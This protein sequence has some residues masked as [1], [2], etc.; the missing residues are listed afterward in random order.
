MQQNGTKI[1]RIVD[2]IGKQSDINHIGQELQD[3]IARNDYEYI[4]FYC[5]GI[6]NEIL[7]NAGLKLKDDS[8]L[9]TIPNYFEPFVQEN[10]DIYYFTNCN[11]IFPIFK[12]DGDQDRPSFVALI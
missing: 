11:E 7:E 5:E 3:L 1:L 9:N 10:I 12:A 6:E 4:D 2:F 8:D